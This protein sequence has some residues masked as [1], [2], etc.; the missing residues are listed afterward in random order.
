MRD[1]VTA[2]TFFK[3]PRICWEFNRENRFEFMKSR[4]CHKIDYHN[5]KSGCLPF[6]DALEAIA[7]EDY[8]TSMFVYY[9]ITHPRDAPVIPR[10]TTKRLAGTMGTKTQR[11]DEVLLLSRYVIAKKQEAL[12]Q[13]PLP[14]PFESWPDSFV[15]SL[16]AKTKRQKEILLKSVENC[17]K[18][19]TEFRNKCAIPCSKVIKRQEVH[20][21]FIVILQILRARLIVDLST[22]R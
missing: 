13:S 8:R 9:E 19:R 14:V 6:D 10:Y 5:E 2:D 17:I 12:V 3:S 18:R 16:L 7:T 20:D 11:G 4:K 15:P 21:E 1:I 22:R